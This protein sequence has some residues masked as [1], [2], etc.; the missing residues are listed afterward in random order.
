MHSLCGN[1]EESIR[2]YQ[3]YALEAMQCLR[4]EATEPAL[5]LQMPRSATA[6][7]KD[8]IEMAL[9]AKYRRAYR[10]ILDHLDCADLSV[11]EIADEIGVTE[12]ALQ[13]AFK[14]QVGMAPAEVLRRCRVERIRQDLLCANHAGV[15]VIETAARWGIPNRST[16]ASV[17]RKYFQE[18]PAQ[19]LEKAQLQSAV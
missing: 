17:Y 13:L 16:L 8:D 7:A 5:T 12:R 18:T 2:H 15:S 9:T 14:S 10:Y 19:T 11:R 4:A 6:P 1:T 3:R